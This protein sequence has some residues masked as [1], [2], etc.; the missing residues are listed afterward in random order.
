MKRSYQMHRLFQSNVGYVNIMPFMFYIVNEMRILG[1]RIFYRKMKINSMSVRTVNVEY[2][3]RQK[4][5][6]CRYQKCDF[7]LSIPFRT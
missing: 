5:H 1:H 6:K 3:M 2:I 7:H 4:G